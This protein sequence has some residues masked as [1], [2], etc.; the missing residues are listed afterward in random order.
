MSS[1]SPHRPGT[2]GSGA[3]PPVPHRGM[4]TLLALVVP[5]ALLA[6]AVAVALSW[7]DDLPDPVATHFGAHGPDGYGSLASFVWPMA[8]GFA[9]GVVAMWAFTILRGRDA[10]ARRIMAGAATFLAAMYAVAVVGSLA[11]QRGLADATQAPDVTGTVAWGACIAAVLA[12]LAAWATPSDGAQPTADPVAP[13]GARVPLAVGERATWVERVRSTTLLA[14][15]AGGVVLLGVLAALLETPSLLVVAVV[16]ALVLASF[17]SFVVT[18]DARGLAARSVLG[19][20]RV[21]IPL[22]EV[23]AAHPVTV[24]PLR[25]FGGW[26]YRVTMSGRVGIVL[27]RGP[28]LEVERTGGRTFVVT[29]DD[30]ETGAALLMSLTERSRLAPG[31]A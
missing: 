30:P 29:V 1:P 19:W 26:G 4:S 2:R 18:V 20:P 21:R 24:S 13:D 15:G 16:I 31:R 28:A 3:R 17:A 14:V 25:E 5:L 10:G 12:A 11:V 27:R 7:A 23:V 6:G 8:V 22:D 9:V